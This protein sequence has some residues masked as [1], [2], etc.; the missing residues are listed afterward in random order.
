MGLQ[1]LQR[2]K[3]LKRYQRERSQVKSQLKYAKKKAMDDANHLEQVELS[4]MKGLQAGRRTLRQMQLS[5]SWLRGKLASILV[6]SRERGR[7]HKLH[8]LELAHEKEQIGDLQAK[9]QKIQRKNND[10]RMEPKRTNLR[11]RKLLHVCL[12]LRSKLE[13]KLAN[14]NRY[15][16]RQR[17]QL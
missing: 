5:E 9:V 7:V 17:T 2:E 3:E 8:E 14:A 4:L 1:N 15:A 11:L 16:R 13:G 6:A 10:D 12:T